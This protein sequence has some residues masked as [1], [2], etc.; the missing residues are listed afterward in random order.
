MTLT[1][2][3]KIKL[4][5]NLVRARKLDE[6][7]IEMFPK[8]KVGPFFHSSRGQEAI[9]VGACTFLEKDDYLMASH[10]GN[11]MCEVLS[12]GYPLKYFIAEHYGKVHGACQGLSGFHVCDLEYG[13]LGMGGTIG[14]QFTV[15]SG[16]G[17]AAKHRGNGQVV[18]SFFGDGATGRGTFHTALLMSANWKLPVIWLCSNNEM[19]MWVPINAAY[20]KENL[21]DLAFGYGIP[22]KVVDGQDVE[23]V[24]EA[25]QE[26]VNRAKSGKGPSF[27]EFKTCRF[28]AHDESHPDICQ[29]AL[30]DE[31]EIRRWEERDPVNLFRKK[32]TDEGMLDQDLIERIDED[33]KHEL[34][35]AERFASED[36]FPDPSILETALY[37]ES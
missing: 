12:K 18:A 16:A 9:G 15:C 2:D 19:G 7:M 33:A 36:S 6:F 29:N 8:G 22:A 31:N 26:A 5:T 10:R 20:P 25:V 21:A 4:Y 14:E 34:E 32:L 35:E 1:T 23:T 37:A 28:R 11:G 24:Y 30:R 17:I 13:I 27:I 3:K